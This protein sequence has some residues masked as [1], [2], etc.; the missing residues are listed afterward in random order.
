[1]GKFVTDFPDLK[2]VNPRGLYDI[3]IHPKELLS[4]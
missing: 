1:M 2:L 4:S 3:A